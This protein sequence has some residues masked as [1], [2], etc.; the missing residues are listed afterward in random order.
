VLVDLTSLA[1]P[2]A[3]NENPFG[4]HIESGSTVSQFGVMVPF[5]HKRI[6]NLAVRI[7]R[8]LRMAIVAHIPL[9][10]RVWMIVRKLILLP[11]LDEHR[12]HPM[13]EEKEW[14]SFKRQ[15]YFPPC[16]ESWIER[17]LYFLSDWWRVRFERRKTRLG[18][19]AARV[20]WRPYV[21]WPWKKDGS[22]E[23]TTY[24]YLR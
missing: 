7:A 2:S 24:M 11:K 4:N 1:K 10:F 8:I 15:H 9:V 13:T 21:R 22:N 20:N 19:S 17:I 3:I 16:K 12:K 23:A 5:I 14:K 6:F 18:K